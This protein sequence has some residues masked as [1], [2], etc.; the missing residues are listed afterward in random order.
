M[1]WRWTFLACVA[2]ACACARPT[3][4]AGPRRQQAEQKPALLEGLVLA[5][6]PSDVR[7]VADVV[8]NG[9]AGE[10]VAVLGEVPPANVVPFNGMRAAFLIMDPADLAKTDVKDE[11]SCPDAET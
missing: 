3:P 4:D 6:K 1:V 2:L 10:A 8:A 11:L 9:K 7:N 5:E